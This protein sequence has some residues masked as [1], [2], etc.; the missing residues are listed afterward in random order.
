MSNFNCCQINFKIYANKLLT[1]LMEAFKKKT[2]QINQ[3]KAKKS[4]KK[5]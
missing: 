4:K 2:P 1:I 5:F 3:T